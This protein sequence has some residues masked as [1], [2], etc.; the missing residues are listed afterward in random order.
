[1]NMPL[2]AFIAHSRMTHPVSE[3]ASPDGERRHG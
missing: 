3:Q 2:G 1:M